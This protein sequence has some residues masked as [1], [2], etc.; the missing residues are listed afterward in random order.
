M[1]VQEQVVVIYAEVRGH[2]DDVPVEDVQR[3][4]SEL[5]AFMR[6]S[7][8]DLLE[9]IASTG[10]LPKESELEAAIAEFKR[11]FG[12]S[13]PAAAAEPT[14]SDGSAPVDVSETEAG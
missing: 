4:E 10:T 11:G 6:A 7:H 2:I 9:H 12:V 5:R 1:P 13:V 14:T 3:F 8:G